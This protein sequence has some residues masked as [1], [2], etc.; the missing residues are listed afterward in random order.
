MENE[1][2]YGDGGQRHG[3]VS[4]EDLRNLIQ[5]GSLKRDTLV[6]KE[7]LETWV[8]ASKVKGLFREPPP[9]AGPPKPKSGPPPLPPRRSARPEVSA[10][11]SL[12]RS[13]EDHEIVERNEWAVFFLSLFTFQFYTLYLYYQWAKDLNYLLGREKY[14][15][16]LVLVL[17][18]VTCGIAGMVYECCYAFEL[19]RIAAKER[20]AGRNDSLGVSVLFL[21]LAPIII[22]FIPSDNELRMTA[23]SLTVSSN[24]PR[25]VQRELNKFA[26]AQRVGT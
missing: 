13:A 4:I 11:D 17:A 6:W 21:R 14:N 10:Q 24:G 18:I 25:L 2:Y 15:P 22:A 20:L 8:P 7:G 12:V 9:L 23:L 5:D 3:P 1:W 19:E 26:A 16:A